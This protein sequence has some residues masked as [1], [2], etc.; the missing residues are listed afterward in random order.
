V[1]TLVYGAILTVDFEDRVLAH[2]QVV[3]GAKLRRGETFHFGW[4]ND[5]TAKGGRT[6]IWVHP[7]IPIVYRFAGTRSPVIN[8][9]WTEQLMASANSVNGLQLTPEPGDDDD[10]TIATGESVVVT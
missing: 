8:R 3:I 6:V 5:G 4:T 2:L 1:G 10:L 7:T 9:L